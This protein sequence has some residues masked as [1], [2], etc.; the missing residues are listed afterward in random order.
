MGERRRILGA[1]A[2]QAG[3][4][5]AP[6]SRIRWASAGAAASHQVQVP[7]SIVFIRKKCATKSCFHCHLIPE[8]RVAIHFKQKDLALMAASKFLIY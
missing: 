5:S 3:H 6:R 8:L 4:P 2:A 7:V 1:A